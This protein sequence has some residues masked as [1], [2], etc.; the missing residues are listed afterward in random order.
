MLLALRV[1][2]ATGTYPMGSAYSY[3]YPRDKI[4]PIKNPMS[5]HGYEIV[6]I[7]ALA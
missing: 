6:P 5:A 4:I 2:M 3:L 7:P 1:W